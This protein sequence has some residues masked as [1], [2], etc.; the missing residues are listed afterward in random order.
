[1]NKQESR[2]E[3]S[4]RRHVGGHQGLP[5]WAGIDNDGD[6]K[7]DSDKIGYGM[8]RRLTTPAVAHALPQ[9][10]A[11][12]RDEF[13]CRHRRPRGQ[14]PDTPTAPD[15]FAAVVEGEPAGQV[16]VARSSWATAAT[17][18]LDPSTTGW[19]LR[20]H[21]EPGNQRRHA[22]PRRTIFSMPTPPPP[23]SGRSTRRTARTTCSWTACDTIDPEAA[24]EADQHSE[25]TTTRYKR[26]M[27]KL[28]TLRVGAFL[29]SFPILWLCRLIQNCVGPSRHR[30]A[31]SPA[32]PRTAA[33]GP[34]R[35]A[36]PHP[37]RSSPCRRCVLI[38]C[39][40]TCGV[41]MTLADFAAGS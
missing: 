14:R 16:R 6:G 33:A 10:R 25:V 35:T 9:P 20:V 41:R 34:S 29:R 40:A 18:F 37:R 19:D 30:R 36:R 31:A 11:H 5:G 17:T 22:P 39:D 12:R 3:R 23:A 21:A 28:Q 38:V 2:T 27:E 32:S 1:M 13:P 24:L 26:G 15:Y 7:L 4:N 8:A